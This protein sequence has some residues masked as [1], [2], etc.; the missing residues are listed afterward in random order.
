MYVR[1]LDPSVLAFSLYTDTH[2][3]IFSLALVLPL[4]INEKNWTTY[5]H[6]KFRRC[7]WSRWFSK[8]HFQSYIRW[9][10]KTVV[11]TQISR[12]LL[13]WFWNHR[14]WGFLHR[15][16]VTFSP[17]GSRLFFSDPNKHPLVFHD[18][19]TSYILDPVV[20]DL[21]VIKSIFNVKKDP[22]HQL[23]TS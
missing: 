9:F 8:G 19:D 15:F 13:G 11:F 1:C 4:I 22:Q 2:S 16:S 5:S 21:C 20:L 12:G 18:T 23:L 6:K 14:S 7:V 17:L 10:H 3:Y